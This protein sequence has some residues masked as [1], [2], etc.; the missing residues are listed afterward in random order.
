[1]ILYHAVTCTPDSCAAPYTHRWS[2]TTT[3]QLKQRSVEM[4][5]CPIGDPSLP[6]GVDYEQDRVEP[7]VTPATSSVLGF[8]HTRSPNIW[9]LAGEQWRRGLPPDDTSLITEQER[10]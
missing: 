7:V 6:G 4:P 3:G 2:V 1:M 8:D 10:Q 9:A 5:G